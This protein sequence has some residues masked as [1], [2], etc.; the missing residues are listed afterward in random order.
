[1]TSGPREI[2]GARL[3]ILSAFTNRRTAEERDKRQTGG[4]ERRHRLL[5]QIPYPVPRTPYPV[6]VPVPVAYRQ[7]KGFTRHIVP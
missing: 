2:A 7:I 6:P 5:R 1:M 4:R 3:D